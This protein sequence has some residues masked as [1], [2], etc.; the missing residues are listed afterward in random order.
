MSTRASLQVASPAALQRLE[1][2][3]LDLLRT[4]A[5]AAAAA[6]AGATILGC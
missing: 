2:A 4:V 5:A 1:G 3:W 6:A